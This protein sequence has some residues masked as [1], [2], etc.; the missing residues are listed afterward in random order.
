MS[1]TA[2]S[3]T[4]YRTLR[5]V[6]WVSLIVGAELA[7]FSLL[8]RSVDE[9]TNKALN[10]AAAMVLFGTIVPLAFRETLQEGGNM[11]ISNLYWIILSQLGTVALASAV[12]K[13]Q[14]HAR[15]WA[16][17]GLVVASAGVAFLAPVRSSGK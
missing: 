3:S 15:E 17:F 16:A 4:Q 12:Y 10:V 1:A 6:G 7:A 14:M 2:A 9:P 5:T 8:Q 13:K 11:A